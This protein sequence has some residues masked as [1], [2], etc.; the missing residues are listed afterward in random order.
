MPKLLTRSHLLIFVFISITL[1][2]RPYVLFYE[3][4]GVMSYIQVLCHFDFIFVYGVKECSKFID[5]TYGYPAFPMPLADKTAFFHYVFLLLL[6][7]ILSISPEKMK[8]LMQKKK[9][10]KKPVHASVHN[11]TTY[12]CQDKGSSLS[13]HSWMNKE[14]LVCVCVCILQIYT[15]T[16]AYNRMLLSHKKD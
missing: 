4:Y 9:K 10:K 15:Y 11:S 2:Y 6:L 3:F 12:N 16:H 5:F 1:G 14:D 7:K 8:A 13:V